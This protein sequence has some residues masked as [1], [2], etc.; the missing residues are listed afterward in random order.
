MYRQKLSHCWPD[1]TG[2]LF[3]KM[4]YILTRSQHPFEEILLRQI[5][6]TQAWRSCNQFELGS[7][8]RSLAV[9]RFRDFKILDEICQLYAT[10]MKKSM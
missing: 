3:A 1:L 4:A 7:L 8:A 9:A 2:K 10:K 5:L 6:N